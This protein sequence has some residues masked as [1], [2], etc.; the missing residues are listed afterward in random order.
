M[1]KLLYLH[2]KPVFRAVSKAE[3]LAAEHEVA[4]QKAV[5]ALNKKNAAR[6]QAVQEWL[7]R[8]NAQAE[9]EKI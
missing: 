8:V 1:G 4:R 3:S 7:A 2:A 6:T 9:A 5:E